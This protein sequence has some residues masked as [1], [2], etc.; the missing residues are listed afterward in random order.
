[1][2][3]NPKQLTTRLNTPADR[4]ELTASRS[5]RDTCGHTKDSRIY[6]REQRAEVT[7]KFLIA[8]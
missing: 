7:K 8:R 2:N 3:K 5:S 1:M 4:L 6:T